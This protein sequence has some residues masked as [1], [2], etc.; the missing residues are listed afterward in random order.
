MILRA[1][2]VLESSHRVGKRWRRLRGLRIRNSIKGNRSLRSS[3]TLSAS[4]LSP[5]GARSRALR[6]LADRRLRGFRYRCI[7]PLFNR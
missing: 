3:P 1:A 4:V 7:E 5:E 6:Y 2:H